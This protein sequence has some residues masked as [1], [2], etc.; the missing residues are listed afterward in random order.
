MQQTVKWA[1]GSARKE[2]VLVGPRHDPYGRDIVTVQIDDRIYKV[3]SC[4]LAGEWMTL[5]GGGEVQLVEPMHC[6]DADARA[7]CRSNYEAEVVKHTGFDSTFWM[8]KLWM[9]LDEARWR[10]DPEA[11]E[12]QQAMDRCDGYYGHM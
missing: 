4:G 10:A 6:F 5:H 9:K 8:H 3:V 12:L 7:R 2:T 11:W 1:R